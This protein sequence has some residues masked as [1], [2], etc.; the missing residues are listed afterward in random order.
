MDLNFGMMAAGLAVGAL[1][2]LT[3]MGAGSLMT[4]ILI[5]VFGIPAGTA[6][7]T[8][9]VY[10]AITKTFGA[11]RHHQLKNVSKELALWMAA[12][13][14]PAAILGTFSLYNLFGDNIDA[15]LPNV[16]GI[17]LVFVGIGVAVRTFVTIRGLWDAAKL[18]TDGQL[19]TRHKVAAVA[20]GVVFGFVLGLTSVGSGVFF[21]MA[22]V[23]VFPLAARRVVGTDVFH[24]MLVTGAAAAGTIL[25]GHPNYAYVGSILIGSIPGI[26]IGSHFTGL[27]PERLLRGLI[28]V[29]LAASGLKTLDAPFAAYAA[30]L[31]VIAVVAVVYVIQNGLLRSAP[32][33]DVAAAPRP[34]PQ[35]SPGF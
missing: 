32:A 14:I 23:T 9:L 1:V 26:L 27:A 21:G 6:V 19:T 3:G 25:W 30:G 29:V 17:A 34:Q 35:R 11:A 18:P 20:I 28:A 33:E 8:D 31:A 15:W 13:S 10:A 12:G 24:A 22:L 2:G 7:G 16:V 5:N 4:P